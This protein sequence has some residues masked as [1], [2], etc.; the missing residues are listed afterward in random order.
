ML[1]GSVLLIQHCTLKMQKNALAIIIGAA[2]ARFRL[3]FTTYHP[4]TL[5]NLIFFCEKSVNQLYKSRQSP[6]SPKKSFLRR[7]LRIEKV[8]KKDKESF[9]L[10]FFQRT[11]N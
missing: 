6:K 4:F 9:L 7:H 5:K 3:H 1:V 11:K 8:T 10:L 2:A